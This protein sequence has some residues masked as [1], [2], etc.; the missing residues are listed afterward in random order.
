MITM[1]AN[2][3][4]MDSKNVKTLMLAVLHWSNYLIELLARVW[5]KGDSTRMWVL[6]PLVMLYFASSAFAQT[7]VSGAIAVNTHWTSANSP[8]LLSGDVVIQNGAILTIDPDVTVY[9]GANTNLNL[10]AGSI[11]AL[12]TSANPI[13]VLSDNT[14]LAQNAAPGDWKQ[15]VFN[16]GTV[17]TR[18]E[19]VL[20]QHGSGLAVI[21][22]APVFNFLTI[23]NHQGAAIS[24]DLAASP[25][26]VGNQATGNTI[27]GITVPAG[28]INGIVNWG[29]RGIPYVVDSGVVSVGISPSIIS[30]TP[31][32]IQQGATNTIEINGTRL[33]G[34]ASVQFDNTGLTAEVLPGATDTQASLSVKATATAA[35][36]ASAAI[37]LVDAGEIIVADALTVVPTQPVLTSLS[38]ATL[39]LGQGVVD[40]QVNGTNFTSLSTVL[41]NNVAVA[42]QYQSAT[43]I[44]ASITTPTNAANLLV[45]VQTPDALHVGQN[46]I[47]NELVLP[48]VMGQ[49]VLSPT[50]ITA[51]KGFTKTVTLTLPYPAVVGGTTVDLVSSVPAVGNVPTTVTIPAGQTSATFT[52]TA[53]EVGSTVVTASKLGFISGPVPITVAPPPTLT[54]APNQLTLGVGRTASVTLQSSV[55]AGI[56]GLAV[57]L[58]SN[59][60]SIATV[61]ASL[62]I[63]AGSSS[64]TFNVTTVAIG[65]AA[66]QATANEFAM[67]SASVIVRPVS[68][69]LPM[70]VLV[71][72]GLSR[73]VP[74]ILS[75][76]APAGGLVVTL[77]S[78][79]PAI[80]IAP[81][82]MTVPEGQTSANFVLTGVAAG[83]TSLTATADNYQPATMAATV[84]TVT[85]GI[86]NPAVSSITLLPDG[87]KSF[88]ITLSHP[89]PTGGVV[90]NLGVANGSVATVAPAS[91]AIAEGQTSG[92]VVLA[93]LTGLAKGDTMLAATSAGLNAASVPVTVTDRP[94]LEF[95]SAT[96]TGSVTVGKG[97][98][99]YYYEVYVYRTLNGGWYSGTDAL[100][101]NLT[102]SNPSK[103]S[104]PAT[105]TIAAGSSYTYFQ[106]M[107]TG[108]TNGAPVT[109][110]ATAQ[111]HSSGTL[112]G[113]VVSPVLNLISLDN[114]RISTVSARDDFTASL[115]VPGAAYSGAQTAVTAMAIDVAVVN[116]NPAGIID[117]LYSDATLGTTVTQ[118]VI[119]QGSNQSQSVYVGTPTT[120]GTYQ[121]QASGSGMALVTSAVQTVSAPEY[122]LG[123]GSATGNSSVTVGKGLSTFYYEVYIYRTLNGGWYSGTVALT[124]N[125]TCSST[126]ICSVPA[127]ITIP[128]GSSFTYFQ[129]IGNDLGNTTITAS[130]VGYNSPAQ[131][132]AVSVIK[133]QLNFSGPPNTVIGGKSNFSLSLLEPGSAYSG[134]QTAINAILIDLTSSAPGVASVP[135]SATIAVGG[136]T[137]NTVQMTGVA[138]GTTTLTASGTGLVSATSSIITINP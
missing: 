45:R 17:N 61:P 98:S 94:V 76:P 122:V 42:T 9:M 13:S 51:T 28:D 128:A 67:G 58:S 52:F 72:P 44:R 123:F 115:T 81:V 136:T 12:G 93:T 80:A 20:F 100:T 116:A 138:V 74:L 125:L 57:N 19:H 114:T 35:I 124:V 92:G 64:V 50:P 86:G 15:W 22:S 130:A 110:E 88:A 18:L 31:Q 62:T 137:S 39:Y 126:L 105:V 65:T 48:A 27:N 135:A 96:G 6:V 16:A 5:R 82:S 1:P 89:A 109:I 106:V 32:L 113:N 10:Q 36:G 43:G 63:P 118:V 30:I 33:T 85:I 23:N 49:L 112:M 104:V 69:N 133:P 79:S 7:P 134:N 34:L 102:S 38:P 78:A 3:K 68:L 55:P 99:T 59:N 66:I 26:G 37:I 11:Q 54:L 8:Y 75:D 90:I 73:S 41:V 83:L 56:S 24:I 127:S 70:G 14:R 77:T 46:L 121:V 108:L 53:T 25:S 97:L 107:G 47:S 29:L 120:A 71:A 40:V 119:P 131:D 60:I 129:I 111:G 87:S 95:G 132:L 103:L 2:T 84:Q 91:I 101:V 21:G 4:R 117:G